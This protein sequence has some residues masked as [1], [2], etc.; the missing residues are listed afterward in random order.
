LFLFQAVA[1]WLFS[2]ADFDV[3]GHY[4]EIT[5]LA[6]LNPEFGAFR[7]TIFLFKVLLAPPTAHASEIELAHWSESDAVLSS[8]Y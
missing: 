4:K 2:T 1:C 6:K 7:D 3:I 8:M 5:P